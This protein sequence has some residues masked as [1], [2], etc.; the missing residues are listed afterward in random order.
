MLATL[1]GRSYGLGLITA[2]LLDDFQGLTETRF[3]WINA[4][5][6]II[7]ALACIPAGYLL[8]RFGT[9]RV[10]AV[11]ILALAGAVYAMTLSTNTT[12]LAI[13]LT[14]TRALGQSM[15]S[16]I[17]LAM[18]GKYFGKNA[19]LSMGGFAVLMTMLLASAFGG[20]S[21]SLKQTDDWRI[22]WQGLAWVLL[23]L[24]PVILITALKPKKAASEP[25]ARQ[26][27]SNQDNGA[28]LSEALNSRYFW[29]FALAM[30]LFALAS[31]GVTLFLQ[32]I[33]AERGVGEAV[34]H[35]AQIIALFTGLF[36]NLLGGYLMKRVAMHRLLAVAMLLLALALAS[37]AILDQDWQAYAY[38]SVFGLS[39]GLTTVLFFAVWVR[40]FGQRELGKIQGAAQLLTVLGSALGPVVISQGHRAAGGHGPT[41]IALALAA[42]LLSAVSGMTTSRKQMA[43]LP[44]QAP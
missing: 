36:A 34:Y 12:Q 8:D 14:L 24:L 2:R 23:G 44:S 25:N 6:A 37:L 10:L 9:R 21:E 3:G 5:A 39:G 18:M 31:S 11:V 35:T 41:L 28:T 30:A 32:P 29:S 26:E 22:V 16:V 38:A 15:L 19:S 1:P 20:L 27:Q 4:L 40:A 13:A 43:D 42:A 7:G 17:S 33:L